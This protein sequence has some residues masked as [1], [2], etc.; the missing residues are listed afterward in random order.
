MPKIIKIPLIGLAILIATALLLLL[1]MNTNWF[2]NYAAQKATNFLTEELGTTV[3]IG[4]VSID[5]FDRLSAKEVYL[6]DLSG[7]TMIYVGELKANYDIFSFTE[8]AIG[9]DKVVISDG[10]IQIG[11]SEGEEALNINH[12]I[13]YFTPPKTDKPASSPLLSFDKVTLSNTTFRYFNENFDKPTSRKFNE[14]DILI[15]DINGHLHN[16]YIVQDSLNFILDDLTGVEQ[17]GLVIDDLSA[18]TTISSRVMEFDELTI[19]TP[20]STIQDYLRFDYESYADFSEF[21]DAVEITA[22]MKNSEVHTDDLALFS[23]NLTLYRELISAS[24]KVTGTVSDLKSKSLELAVGNHTKFLG[25]AEI[26]GIPNTDK[27]VF[28]ISAK[29]LTT[30]TK[31]LARVIGLDPAPKEFLNIG[32]I[33]YVGNYYG[34]ISDFKTDGLVTTSVGSVTTALSYNQPKGGIPSYDGHV[35]SESFDLGAVIEND[36]LGDASFDLKVAGKGITQESL[37]A[38]VSGTVSHLTYDNYTY[39][40]MKVDGNVSDQLFKGNFGIDD[41]NYAF[42][43]DGRLDLSK[44]EPIILATTDVDRINLQ[45]L[46]LDSIAN[47]F[48]FKGDISIQGNS[49]DNARGTIDLDSFTIARNGENYR[50]KDVVINAEVESNRRRYVLNSDLAK[51]DITGDFVPSEL[52]LIIENIKHT[53]YPEQFPQPTEEL[54]TNDITVEAIIAEYKP[55]FK[56]ILGEVFFDSAYT[57]VSYN[58]KLGKI[59]GNSLLTSLKYDVVST[60]S[61]TLKLK[62]GGNFT[63]INFGINTSGLYQ[64]DSTLFEILNMNGFIRDGIVNFEATS[65]RDTLLDI[66]LD[67]RFTY[68]N[69]SIEVYFDKSQ[70]EINNKPWELKK[71]DFPNIINAY[72]ITEFRYFFFQNAEEILF[73]DASI[74]SNANKVNANLINFKLSN[75]SPFLTGFDLKLSGLTNGYI[76]VSDREGFPIIEAD[77]NIADLQLDEDTLGTLNLI[78]TNKDGL[79]AVALDGSVQ[80]GLLNDMKILGDIDFKNEKSPLNLTL[81]SDS[82]SIKPFEKYLVGLASDIQGVSTSKV[83][84]TGPLTS[85]QLKGN[86][87]LDSLQFVVDY[88]QTTYTA[89]ADVVIDYNSFTLTNANIYDRFGKKG[90]IGGSVYHRNFQNFN[91]D[92]AISELQNFEIMNTKRKD[93]ELFYGTAFVDGRMLVTGPL[94]DIYLRIFAKSRRGTKIA[95]PLDY[96]STSGKLPYVEFVNLQEDTMATSVSSQNISGVRMDFNIEVT[97]D[98]EISLIFDELLGDKIDAAGHGNLRMEIN[99]FGDFNMYGGLTVDRGNYLFTALNLIN[100]YFTVEPGGTLFWDG[101]P[102]NARIDIEAIKREYPTPAPLLRGYTSE[103]DISQYDVNI[104]VDCYLQLKGLLFAPE[105]TFDL[106]FPNQSSLSGSAT[107]TLN[108]TVERIKLDQEELNR[109]VFALLVLGTFIPP[110]FAGASGGEFGAGAENAG[111]NSLSDFASSQLNNWLSQLDTRLKL[112]VDYQA[113]S[114][115]IDNSELIISVQGKILSRVLNDKLSFESSIDAAGLGNDA[116]TFT[117]YDLSLQYDINEDGTLSI[118]GFQKNA[119]DPTLNNLTN[120][121][122]TGV[123]LS[124]KY[125]FDKFRFRIKKIEPKEEED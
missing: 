77:L 37:F 31:D 123:G 66:V 10:F 41:P 111:I 18:H 116:T 73:L 124:Y 49:L 23:N 22:N 34:S 122:T 101:D 69:D 96:T 14:N 29:R 4:E 108:T 36:K 51:I 32:N 94:D 82:S 89:N 44:D 21:I 87:R 60:P 50:L 121:N 65:K 16:F 97:N 5:Y 115:E 7:D 86:M 9:L 102:Y 71:A 24:G 6:E 83:K 38:Q 118:R 47:V 56:E 113:S 99:T 119:A 8:E 46:G 79:L 43:F 3:S 54:K 57:Y 62:N 125:Q 112:G 42:T 80:G 75:L 74:G 40:Y 13:K 11:I 100:K 85:P 2:K 90:K 93:N 117:P 120:V 104:P 106:K 17:S 70:V 1:V 81:T 39:H 19:L 52:S 64:N 15:R 84:I 68:K 72:G 20:M 33:D 103:T 48:K 58:H 88:L 110:S 107:S 26:M 109:Q 61:L 25:K 67:G 12:F 45:A 30:N 59:E 53:I 76:D 78:S 27:M 92:I 91:F 98:A 105:V 95:I 114:S 63:P 28:D 35:V 55:I